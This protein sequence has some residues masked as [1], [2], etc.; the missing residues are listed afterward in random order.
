MANKNIITYGA[1]LTGVRESYYSP[2]SQI[3]S[4]NSYLETFYCF[5]A[6]VDPWPDENVPPVPT[7]DQRNLKKIYKNIFVVKK[8]GTN[9][10]SPVVQR[11]D[12]E[13][14]QTYEYYR[15]DVDMLEL[16]EN[17]FLARRF[18]V[19][20]RFDQ[21]FKC[22]WNNNGGVVSDEPYFQPGTY[23]SNNLYLGTDGYKWKYMYTVDIGAKLKFM[24]TLW[25]PI[26][27]GR[28]GPTSQFYPTWQTTPAGSG[29]IDVINVTNGG[30]GYN[31][32]ANPVLVSITGDGTGATGTAVVVSN[33]I[34]NII[35][36]NNG[37]NY[38]YANVRIT[39][40]S[41]NGATA[42]APV[43]PIS[44]HGTDP[45]SELGC[46]HVMFTA[47]FNGDENGLIPVDIDFR[48]LGIIANPYS[49]GSYPDTANSTIYKTTTDISVVSGSGIYLNDETV[50]QGNSLETASFKA[51]VLSFD[52]TTGVVRLINTIGTPIVNRTLFGSLSATA[53]TTLAISNPDY[54]IFSGHII[55]IENRS[56]IQRSADGIEQL[57]FVLGY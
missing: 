43:S 26:P 10:I 27:I 47:E 14:G 8:V 9:N 18:Y 6:K 52:D 53:R 42:I 1:R 48:Q 54:D 13:A 55:F 50:Y 19:K 51:T 35:V 38:T 46:S 7:Q 3:F 2:V 36:T 15:D 40:T 20:N 41:G 31:P 21:V 28:P 16:D 44:G 30:S 5:L 29:N 34:T 4:T 23:T 25:M 39:S 49:Q 33:T 22:L 17:G 37:S 56:S 24:D 32:I 57:R 12:W 11:F 45:I